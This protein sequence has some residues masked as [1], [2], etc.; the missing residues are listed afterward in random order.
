[1]LLHYKRHLLEK[2]LHQDDGSFRFSSITMNDYDIFATHSERKSC[3]DLWD[4]NKDALD[5]DQDPRSYPSEM[6]Y[7]TLNESYSS[8]ID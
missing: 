4:D 6:H 5:S 2:D 8:E 1:M 7:F 3:W